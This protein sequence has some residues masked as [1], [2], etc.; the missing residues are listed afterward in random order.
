MTKNNLLHHARTMFKV[1]TDHSGFD[2]HLLKVEVVAAHESGHC[3]C[4]MPLET[5]H[6]NRYGTLHG[7]LTSTLVDVVS[8]MSVALKHKDAKAGVSVGLN[9]E[10]IG[11]G[12]VGDTISIDSKCT[13][14]GKSLA[15]TETVIKSE[16][17][18]DVIAR[19]SHTKF[20][21]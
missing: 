7:G 20:V 6:T 19:A 2:R 21:G 15:F 17:T 1:I 9:V 8:S 10:F 12:K 13:K 11:P 4:R 18:G 3:V 14:V 16:H 5:E